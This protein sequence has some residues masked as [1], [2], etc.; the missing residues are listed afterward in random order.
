MVGGIG[1]ARARSACAV[2][3]TLATLTG[4]SLAQLADDGQGNHLVKTVPAASVQS[5]AQALPFDLIAQ[6]ATVSELTYHSVEWAS[7]PSH[8]KRMTLDRNHNV[9]QSTYGANFS[10]FYF[11]FDTGDP[12]QIQVGTSYDFVALLKPKQ[13]C[14]PIGNGDWTQWHWNQIQIVAFRGTDDAA[15]ILDDVA[16]LS[17]GGVGLNVRVHVG[18]Y[19]AASDAYAALK[20]HL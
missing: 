14:Q 4:C 3:A 16:A 7:D 2:V 1:S 5:Q 9:L 10:I 12:T 18:F 20:P 13:P 17:D 8:P 6:A 15:D 19:T 11:P